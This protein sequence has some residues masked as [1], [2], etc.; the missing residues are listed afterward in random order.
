MDD[1]DTELGA[2]RFRY[3]KMRHMETR[4]SKTAKSKLHAIKNSLERPRKKWINIIK[5]IFREIEVRR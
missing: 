1:R 5:V 2:R 4:I 3:C